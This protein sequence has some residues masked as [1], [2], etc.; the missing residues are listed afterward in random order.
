MGKLELY[1]FAGA[2]SRMCY[3]DETQ[4]IPH[5]ESFANEHDIVTRLGSLA[6]DDFHKEDLIRIDGSLFTCDRYGHLLNAHYLPDFVRGNY[7]LRNDKVE[8]CIGASVHDPVRGNPCLKHPKW[9]GGPAV[10]KLRDHYEKAQHGRVT[11][12]PRAAHAVRSAP[13]A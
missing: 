8:E 9:V 12:P 2:A 5:I 6:R 4:K 3:I 10:S 13:T 1:M 11:V 7:R